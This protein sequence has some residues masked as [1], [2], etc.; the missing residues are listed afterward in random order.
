MDDSFEGRPNQI[1]AIRHAILNCT[2]D[3]QTIHQ[4]MLD[5]IKKELDKPL[6]ETDM[7]YVNACLELLML[8]NRERAAS[9]GIHFGSSLEAI[10]RKLRRR[11]ILSA[12]L[13]PLRVGLACGMMVLLLFS[14]VL[15][16]NGR[17]NVTVSPD[18]EQII[19]Q[20][21]KALEQ[22]QSQADADRNSPAQEMATTEK[23]DEAI[24]LYGATPWM[25]IWVP[26][27]WEAYLYN[28]VLLDSYNRFTALYQS[29]S[30]DE[31]LTFSEKAMKDISL[32]RAEI[33]Q[34]EYG[35][36]VTLQSG[37]VV[38]ITNN[39]ESTVGQWQRGNVLY[40][41]YGPISEEDLLKCIE[42]TETRKEK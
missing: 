13:P 21:E 33:E 37:T 25:P 8:L 42:S 5:E 31:N 9:I 34:N 1:E 41:M 7:N 20:G 17:V 3:A 10:R 24:A 18:E 35:H 6:D 38:Y 14:G 28:V 15:F 29:E 30:L 26:D 36:T 16:P 22:N 11:S 4:T 39:Y 40:T 23:W 32:L 12:T 27:G 19:L 2:L